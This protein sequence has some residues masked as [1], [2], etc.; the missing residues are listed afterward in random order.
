MAITRAL[1]F[2]FLFLAFWTYSGVAQETDVQKS[3]ADLPEPDKVITILSQEVG[4]EYTLYIYLPESYTN[5]DQRYP[6]Q[7]VLDGDASLDELTVTAFKDANLSEVITVGIGYGLEASE[8]RPNRLQDLTSEPVEGLEYTGGAKYFLNFIEKELIPFME[9]NYRVH[10]TFRSLAG[11]SLSGFFTLYTL[12]SK[13]VL[14]DNYIAISPSLAI[15]NFQ[16]E[17]ARFSVPDAKK[18]RL[19]L[20]IG[21]NENEHR[22]KVP[23][24]E[25]I[26]E[27]TFAD[28]KDLEFQSTVID[29]SNHYSVVLPALKKAVFWM[30]EDS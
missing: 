10:T 16:E 23:F 19:F 26:N 29:S 18:I 6:V 8:R 21:E 30:D 9:E 12:F 7:Y 22:M 24:H 17:R 13:P 2:V 25:F 3:I 4:R 14:F 27:L 20:A 15:D 11:H 1:V 5:S 28:F